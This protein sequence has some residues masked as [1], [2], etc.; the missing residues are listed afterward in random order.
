MKYAHLR[1][2]EDVSVEHYIARHDLTH[3][4]THPLRGSNNKNKN[5]FVDLVNLSFNAVQHIHDSSFQ[6][7]Q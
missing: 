3:F 2:R 4:V 1:H 6:L 5:R 7:R